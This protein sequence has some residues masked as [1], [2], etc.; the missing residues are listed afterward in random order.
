MDVQEN[1]V[2][3]E[4]FFHHFDKFEMVEALALLRDDATWWIIGTPELFPFAGAH[5]K[6]EMADIWGALGKFMPN[7]METK[8]RGMIAEG[9]TVS[10]ELESHGIASDGRAYS[11]RYHDVLVVR[12]GAIVEVREYFDT[13]HVADMFLR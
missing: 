3:V 7:G 1:K 4:R 12:N 11:N 5:T 13:Q 9:D 8:I 2:I 6:T 10:V